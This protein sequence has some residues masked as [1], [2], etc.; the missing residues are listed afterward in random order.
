MSTPYGGDPNQ[1]YPPPGGGPGEPPAYP[2][3]GQQGYPPPGS[4]PGGEFGQPDYSQV[5]PDYGQPMGQM[6][7]QLAG[8]WIRFGGSIID[9]ILLSIV[10]NVLG[11][12]LGMGTN[13]RS[14]LNLLIGAVYFTYMHGS[15]GQ[16]L[17]QM[18]VSLKVI[19]QTS[20]GQID[21]GRAF[22]RWLVSL[23]SGIVIGL[24]Y[25]W[26]LWDPNK[27]TWHDKAARVVVVKT[28]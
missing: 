8:F 5:Q 24:G 18:A 19:D 3:P 12:A 15:R 4:G 13:P 9:G 2:P 21:Y 1:G 16:S 10:A 20:G 28:T 11:L 17:G 14:G 25:L 7:R 6:P 22:V 26:M 27:Q 23:V